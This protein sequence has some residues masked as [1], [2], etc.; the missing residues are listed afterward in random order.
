VPLHDI[1][2]GALCAMGATA[3]TETFLFFWDHKN[4][5]RCHTF[6]HNFWTPN[7]L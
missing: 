3:F 1:M 2:V 6:C 5:H 7:R 4:S